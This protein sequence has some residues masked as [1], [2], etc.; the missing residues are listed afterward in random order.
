MSFVIVRGGGDLASGVAL[1]LRQSGLPVVITEL[2]MP[3]AVRRRVSFASAVY[4][5][6]ILVN[7]C[8][9]CRV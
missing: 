3:L 1:R 6:H 8:L 2:P 5:G 7:D 4:T 9:A